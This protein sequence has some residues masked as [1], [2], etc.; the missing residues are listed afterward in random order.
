MV[1]S[2]TVEAAMTGN[3]GHCPSLQGCSRDGDKG[4]QMLDSVALNSVPVVWHRG[5]RGHAGAVAM[6]IG[7]S[8]IVATMIQGRG[9]LIQDRSHGSQYILLQARHLRLWWR[10]TEA[11]F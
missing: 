2:A 1:I 7:V 3:T 6:A 9:R 4:F 8:R 11:S 5:C 10:L